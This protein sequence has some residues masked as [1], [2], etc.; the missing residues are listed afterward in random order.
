MNTNL[1]AV[2]TQ[3]LE[4]TAKALEKNNMKAYICENK[5]RAFE[6]S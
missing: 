4:R 3:K 6:H 1:D 2:I 5:D